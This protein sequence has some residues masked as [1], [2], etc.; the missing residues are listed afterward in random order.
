MFS[1]PRFQTQ[2]GLLGI[3][4]KDFW[5]SEKVWKAWWINDRLSLLKRSVLSCKGKQL[6]FVCLKGLSTGLKF[7]LRENDNWK[8][9]KCCGVTFNISHPVANWT[10][11]FKK[12]LPYFVLA[13]HSKV[14]FTLQSQ[15]PICLIGYTDV[16]SLPHLC[17][18]LHVSHSITS[19]KK[20]NF[21]ALPLAVIPD[22][23]LTKSQNLEPYL[24]LHTHNIW[25]FFSS[26]L[27][28]ITSNLS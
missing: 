13:L 16:Y 27:V 4:K 1:F 26:P 19:S 18:S 17:H 24:G 6:L 11:I 7:S 9:C 25:C 12:T 14:I 10:V 21:K 5:E 15:V 3:S 2:A 20:S 22:Q 23:L 28:K 8:C